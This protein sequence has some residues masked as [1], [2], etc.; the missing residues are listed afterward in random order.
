MSGKVRSAGLEV[1]L[2]PEE[3]R[4]RNTCIEQC[5]RIREYLPTLEAR[6]RAL[7]AELRETLQLIEDEKRAADELAW[8]STV[9][10]EEVQ[11]RDQKR[12]TR[13]DTGRMTSAA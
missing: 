4:R 5:W 13:T 11:A 12:P 1:E 7:E 9:S 6:A 10:L 3:K 2:S 8:E